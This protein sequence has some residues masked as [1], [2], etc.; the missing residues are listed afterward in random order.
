MKHYFLLFMFLCSAIILHAQHTEKYLELTKNI[1]PIDSFKATIFH[2]NK[3]INHSV[4]SY[5]Y[6]INND[7]KS[8]YFGERT[9]YTTGGDI[10]RTLQFDDFGNVL[11]EVLFDKKGRI[12]KEI[13]A[14]EI[15]FK[16]EIKKESKINFE[17]ETTVHSEKTY[18]YSRALKAMFLAKEGKLLDNKRHGKWLFYK[19]NGEVTKEKIYK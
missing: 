6:N 16:S 11:K 17:L 1:K 7:K 14:L 13:L 5:I 9:Y 2:K 4:K 18:K 19:E 8:C 10:I 15:D 3:H 12:T